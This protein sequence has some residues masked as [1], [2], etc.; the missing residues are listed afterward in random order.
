MAV[1]R[2]TSI[3]TL[4]PVALAALATVTIVGALACGRGVE[5]TPVGAAQGDD[6]NS[7]TDRPDP[8]VE[9]AAKPEIHARFTNDIAAEPCTLLTKTMVGSIAKVEARTINH[10]TPLG[11]MCSYRWD[12]G[13]EATIGFIDVYVDEQTAQTAF[14]GYL[15]KSVAV[16]DPSSSG[17]SKGSGPNSKVNAATIA[18]GV[19]NSADVEITFERIADLGDEALFDTTVYVMDFGDRMVST[20]ANK[21]HVRV[22]NFKFQVTMRVGKDAVV[23]RAATL[24]LARLVVDGLPTE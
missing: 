13:V 8:P 1:T 11:N 3:W 12:D 4:P 23:N 9:S 16:P 14:K 15:D 5:P 19:A 24:D 10:R 6:E 22:A 2:S 17:S 7:P 18:A 21:A 20:P